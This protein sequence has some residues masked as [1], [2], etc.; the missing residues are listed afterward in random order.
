MRNIISID[1]RDGCSCN[2]IVATDT[3]TNEIVIEVITGNDKKPQL[4]LINGEDTSYITLDANQ[5][6]YVNIPSE[7]WVIGGALQF[8][9]E[10]TGRTGELY[11]ISFPQSINDITVSQISE[12]EF[13]VKSLVIGTQPLTVKDIVN[14]LTSTDI[15]KVLSAYQGKV[16][17][18]KVTAVNKNVTELTGDVTEL[19]DE[20]S[21]LITG[22]N[23]NGGDFNNLGNKSFNGQGSNMSNAPIS[24]PRCG[25]IIHH[26]VSGDAILQFAKA[27][28][29]SSGEL[30]CF[31][32]RRNNGNW[33]NWYRVALDIE[34]NNLTNS[35]TN[36]SNTLTT[37]LDNLGASTTMVCN[38]ANDI[39]ET[40][41]LRTTTSS[42][43]VKD[44][45]GFIL[46][47]ATAGGACRIQMNFSFNT[48]NTKFIRSYWYGNWYPWATL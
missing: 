15:Y 42:T 22:V 3:K 17:D 38:D 19:S 31:R 16:L 35:T 32:Q 2:A 29:W 28:N 45:N 33:D 13:S 20:L 6:N 9:Y 7:S 43:N 11:T 40:S 25:Y 34:I 5:S 39:S 46:T 23:V 30:L 10:A 24:D 21:T 1:T 8:Q 44:T 36:L 27:T 47:F 12:T 4:K 41:F 14:N 48:G 37:L 26:I 18:D